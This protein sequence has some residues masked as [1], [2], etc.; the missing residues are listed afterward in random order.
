MGIKSF[1][2]NYSS[3]SGLTSLTMLVLS[4][5]Q[6]VDIKPLVDNTGI[7]SSDLIQLLTNSLNTTSCTSYIPQLKNRGATVNHNCP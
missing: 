5:N 3:L 6:I 2:R 1:D 4:N 7:N